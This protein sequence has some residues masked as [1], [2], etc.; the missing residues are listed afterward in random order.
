MS[1]FKEI[2]SYEELNKLIHNG[3]ITESFWVSSTLV[4]K[5]IGVKEIRIGSLG[6]VHF[7]NLTDIG[8]LE[9]IDCNL[10]FFGDLNSLKNLKYIGGV[11]RFGA[12]LKS[13]GFLQE[14]KADFRPTTSDLED[15]GCLQRVGGTLDLRGLTKL[16]DLSPLREVGG[17]L[18]LVKS[19][20]DQYDL[21]KI[22]IKG[23]TIYWNT[24]PIFFQGSTILQSTKIPP[25]WEN[26]GPYEFEK[27]L[28][29]PN[30]EQLDFYNHFKKSFLNGEYVDVGGMRN[31]IRYYIYELRNQYLKDSDFAYLSKKYETLRKYYPN[32]SHDTENIE[33]EIGR[34]LGIDKYKLI[35]L[36]HEVGINWE[37]YIKD[38]V[39]KF[40]QRIS[41]E[42]ENSNNEDFVRLLIIGLKV[43]SLTNFG[44]ENDKEIHKMVIES[45]R[46]NEEKE[47]VL[48]SRKFVDKNK[49]YKADPITNCFNP[50]L[51]MD[52]FYSNEEFDL[53]MEEHNQRMMGVP[54]E[55][56]QDPKY[57][58]PIVEF[59][60]KKTFI[61]LLRESENALR[62]KLGLPLIG[63]GWIN[64]TDLYY[65]IKNIFPSYIILQHGRPKWLGLQHFDIYF[66]DLNIAIEYQGI[67]H[68]EEIEIFG[69]KEALAKAQ[70]N[71]QIKRDKCNKHDCIL[72]EIL[73]NTEFCVVQDKIQKAILSKTI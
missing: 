71:D 5:L 22:R 62:E 26:H 39:N 49:F 1:Y 72:I 36:P 43:N 45:I 64:E 12:P 21:S 17:N 18:N 27:N 10:S 57:F 23:R 40:T 35:E 46:R 70:L 48:F 63:E 14:I 51:Y 56:I 20:K 2:Y 3:I 73:P 7:Q 59:S 47:N 13:L 24:K 65:K 44:K 69:G 37:S 30:S 55:N 66:S 42:G 58:P 38:L 16:T 52:F 28:V 32:L 33:V 61:R 8:E 11:F 15:L 41:I 67:Q 68:F 6:S 29:I 31:Y 50:S 19:L 60:L 34:E 54:K 4:N 25:P 53:Y 9:Y